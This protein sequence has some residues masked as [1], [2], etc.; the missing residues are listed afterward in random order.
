ML[1]MFRTLFL[2]TKRH[3]E[4]SLLLQASGFFLEEKPYKRFFFKKLRKTG[5]K[6]LRGFR[7]YHRKNEL[8]VKK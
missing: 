2:F 7:Q 1:N 6:K 4:L 8:R 5:L 3:L